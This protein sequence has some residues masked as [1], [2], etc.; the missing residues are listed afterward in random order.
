LTR[1]TDTKKSLLHLYSGIKTELDTI[2]IT[3]SGDRYLKEMDA[4]C[5]ESQILKAQEAKAKRRKVMTDMVDI[6]INVLKEN[7]WG[8]FYKSE[9]MQILT[10]QD[11][12]PLMKVNEVDSDSLESAVLDYVKTLKLKDLKDWAL[13]DIEESSTE[14]T[15]PPS[16]TEDN[17]N[18]TKS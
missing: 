3:S 17:L 15:A 6:L 18:Q 16:H 10:L 1:K 12:A 13:R 7:N 14:G 5:A 2:Y 8:V 9:P 4:I 11:G